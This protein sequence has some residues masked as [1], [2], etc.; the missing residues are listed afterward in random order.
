MRKIFGSILILSIAVIFLF[1]CSNNTAKVKNENGL[2]DV[3]TIENIGEYVIIRGED[4]SEGE[5]AAVSTM[6]KAV[7]TLTGTLPKV[8][9][10]ITSSKNLILIGKTGYKAS[11]NAAAGLGYFDFTIKS[12]GDNLIIA[13][14]SGEATLEAVNFYIENFINSG[15][16]EAYRP[17]WDDG[18]TVTAPHTID[19]LTIDGKD[20]SELAIYNPYDVSFAEDFAEKLSR[21]YVGTRINLIN[22]D[23]PEGESGI[24]IK[25]DILSVT[26]YGVRIEDGVLYIEGGYKSV[27]KAKEKFF[28]LLEGKSGTVALTAA[29]SISGHTEK[30]EIP[31]SSK[32]ELLDIVEYVYNLDDKVILGQHVAGRPTVSGI[33]EEYYGAVGEYPAAIDFDMLDL[34]YKDDAHWSRC[35]YDLA[36]FASRGGII[37]TMYHWANP[38]DEGE[39]TGRH[40]RGVLGT[41]EK[42]NEVLTEGTE[43]NRKW[44]VELDTGA[45][46]LGALKEAGVPV[47]F[48]PMHEANGGFFWFCAPQ[49]ED[50]TVSQEDMFRMWKYV[51]DYYTEELGLDN[52]IWVYGPNISTSSVS[53]PVD[54]YYPGEEYCDIVSLDWYTSGHYEVKDSYTEIEKLGR[55]TALAELGIAEIMRMESV[56]EQMELFS[57]EDYLEIINQMFKD[58]FKIAY[59]QIYAGVSGAPAYLG[60]G[61]LLAQSDMIINLPELQDIIKTV[62]K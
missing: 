44:M 4:C 40:Y 35:L 6:V 12:D 56:E 50:Y 41:P 34:P 61:E 36:E 58:G 1:S 15:K 20:V 3:T 11:E 10:E 48:R 9:S 23:I 24:V 2:L 31:Y 17:I 43:L 21:N 29:D 14:G 8:N 53:L 7:K 42:W 55:I 37:T 49:G 26:K 28:T 59:I 5:N 47:L 54:Y 16:K 30:L 25:N 19:K 45:R 62:L 33:L 13:A 22:T 32:D 38:A 52:I 57:C 60:N 27:E 39:Y 51:Y 18:Y 46:F